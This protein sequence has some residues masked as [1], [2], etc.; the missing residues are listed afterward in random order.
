MIP[1]NDLSRGFPGKVGQGMEINNTTELQKKLRIP[2]KNLAR[3]AL[4]S[5][6]F[7]PDT[8]WQGRLKIFRQIIKNF[9]YPDKIS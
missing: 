2:S 9:N 8:P 4:A 1:A 5:R 7:P 3:Q 6:S